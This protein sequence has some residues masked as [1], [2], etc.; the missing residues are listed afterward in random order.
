[1]LCLLVTAGEVF[2]L[3]DRASSEARSA[4]VLGLIGLL[5]CCVTIPYVV[6]D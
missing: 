1:M 5:V 2:F 3:A 4:L 6:L